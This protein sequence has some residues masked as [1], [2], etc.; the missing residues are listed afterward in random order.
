M[1]FPVTAVGDPYQAIYGWRGAA[2]ANILEF[3]Y[4]FRRSD[5]APAERQ[6]L[7]INRRS[8]QRI[9]DVGNQLAA[10]SRRPR[11]EGVSLVAPP[12]HGP[13]PWRPPRS[14]PSATRSTG[15]SSSS[16]TGTRRGRMGRSGG[17][18]A[19]QRPARPLFEALRDRDVPVEIVGLGGLLGLPEIAPIVSTLRVLDDVAANPDVAALLSGP[20]WA[21]G[22]SDLEA[23]GARARE[24]AGG[25][26]RLRAAGPIRCWSPSRRPI[27][28]RRC[29]SWTP[30]LIRGGSTH[31]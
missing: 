4:H 2:A 26:R 21:L 11:G 28:G 16:S 30:S 25:V 8:G 20:R 27:P 15:S 1:G 23:L 14:T 5:G 3:P 6:T 31:R 24:L 10:G 29:A 19:A 18:R 13:G 9:L 7:S 17:S 12:G 22:L